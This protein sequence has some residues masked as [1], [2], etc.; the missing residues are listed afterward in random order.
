[1]WVKPSK[2]TN[3]WTAIGAATSPLLKISPVKSGN[4]VKVQ[5]P[6]WRKWNL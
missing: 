3:V 5:P 4:L 1:M 6:R 2:C